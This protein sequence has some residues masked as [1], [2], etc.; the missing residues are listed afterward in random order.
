MA[1][2][3]SPAALSM[4]AC[5]SGSAIDALRALERAPLQLPEFVKHTASWRQLIVLETA[6]G[7]DAELV[8]ACM[9]L[10]SIDIV[11]PLD[12]VAQE[13]SRLRALPIQQR[14]AEAWLDCNNAP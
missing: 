8:S 11:S 9:R 1:A 3:Q 7:V 5:A 4:G 14:D 10:L 6:V 2:Q 12:A 13:V